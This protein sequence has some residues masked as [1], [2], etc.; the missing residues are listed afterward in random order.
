MH[1]ARAE[2][3]TCIWQIEILE[4]QQVRLAFL[5]GRHPILRSQPSCWWKTKGLCG[6][7]AGEILSLEGYCVLLAR[8]AS[9]SHPA[10]RGYPEEVQLLLTDLVLPDRDGCDLAQEL[11]TRSAASKAI[12][13]SGYPENRV[14]RKG[15]QR[16]GWF[17][18]PKPFSATS[19]LQ[20]IHDVLRQDV[21]QV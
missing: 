9:G 13:I 12:F 17:Y 21:L 18:L 10:F 8:N 11:A 6:E 3:K 4:H 7:V 15:L 20:K 5:P 19:L 2:V 16:P 1:I 14:T